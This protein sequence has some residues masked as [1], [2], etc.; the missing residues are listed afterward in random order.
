MVSLI[1]LDHVTKCFNR[2]AAVEDLSLRVAP[3]E[4]YA[5]LGPNG[6]GKTTTIKMMVGLLKPDAGTVRVCGHVMGLDG[7]AAKSRIAYVPDQPFLYDKLTGREFLQFVGRMYGMSSSR[8]VERIGQLSRRLD[9][10][11]WLDQYSESYSHGM[12]QRVVLTSAL[13]HDP[14]VLIVDEPMIGL[15]PITSRA[16][17]DLFRDVRAAGGAVFLSTHTLDTAEDLAD[18]I[19]IINKAHLVVEGTLAELQ[20]RTGPDDRLEEIFL[21]VLS[22]A[23]RSESGER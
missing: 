20:S 23:D 12:K 18:R 15:D 9:L 17:K 1:E 6:A 14:D 4:I 16:V 19:G 8:I 13:L 21:K 10:G 3:G 22:E 2:H 7:R 11:D 5:F